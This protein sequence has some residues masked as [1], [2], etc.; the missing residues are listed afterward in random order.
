MNAI[1][2]IFRFTFR[3]QARKKSY[4][5]STI[6]LILAAVA[7]VVVPAL[8]TRTQGSQKATDTAAKST[9]YLA[10]ET[11]TTLEPAD[12]QKLMPDYTVKAVPAGQLDTVQRTV[13][14]D[15][16]DNGDV[17][18]VFR[19][20]Q[21][22]TP[23]FSYYMRKRDSGVD[24]D[25]LAED[26]RYLRAA[27]M[28]RRSALSSGQ[29]E[30]ILRPVQ[31]TMQAGD[32]S[33]DM[34][35]F[36]PAIAVC[37]LLFITIL[38]Y[39]VWVAMSIAS[40]KT[41]H[42]LEILITSTKPSRIIIGKSLAMGGL[43]LLQLF[44]VLLSGG[45][46]YK[47]IGGSSLALLSFSG[48][49]PGYILLLLI[50]FVLGF[51]LYAMLNAVAGATVSSADD[52]RSAV[53]PITIL[54]LISFYLSYGA[55]MAPG[56]PLSLVASLIPFSAAFSM[57]ARLVMSGVPWW[58]IVISL[59][60]LAGTTCAMAALSIRLYTSAVLHYGNRLKLRDLFRLAKKP[61]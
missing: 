55:F 23:M 30:N 47:V 56:T 1:G 20:K 49:T 19:E 36:I 38:T 22:G 11:T 21:D 29:A 4:I 9:L 32:R 60:L 50:Y 39:G 18:V 6:V 51:A 42:V 53:Q 35:G 45:I 59:L 10:D 52:V 2:T 46:A 33:D 44:L 58:Q 17:L 61:H 37:I 40:E 3:E 24:P 28:L 16:N 27:Q 54:G 8:V 5:I 34:S 57:P 43:G 12:V 48:F 15:K 14:S 13:L 31:Y 26:F 41:S 25:K 7:I